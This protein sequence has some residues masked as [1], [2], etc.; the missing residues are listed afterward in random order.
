MTEVFSQTLHVTLRPDV[1][2]PPGPMF[3]AAS[4]RKD[5]LRRRRPRAD[6][7]GGRRSRSVSLGRDRDVCICV[8]LPRRAVGTNRR[9]RSA[10]CHRDADGHVIRHPGTPEC[11]SPRCP[12]ARASRPVAGRGCSPP[13]RQARASP[14]A[15]PWGRAWLLGRSSLERRG[16]TLNFKVTLLV[17]SI[18]VP[19]G[20]S[21]VALKDGVA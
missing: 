11:R 8:V 10:P 4:Q 1:R 14:R 6:S 7:A 21:N 15:R 20:L 9:G 17:K 5:A 13:T 12:R 3:G 16:R 2:A 18:L 19:R